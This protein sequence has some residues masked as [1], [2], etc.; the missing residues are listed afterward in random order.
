M[1]PVNESMLHLMYEISKD[2]IM[3]VL[4]SA[5]SVYLSVR[6]S[7]KEIKNNQIDAAYTRLKDNI[8]NCSMQALDIE[9]VPSNQQ[10]S[11]L[12]ILVGEIARESY[13]FV[14]IATNKDADIKLNSIIKNYRQEITKVN[15][16]DIRDR[17]SVS[18][19]TDNLLAYMDQVYHSI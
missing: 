17:S 5:L 11:K 6:I 9:G 12:T 13:S 7:K 1:N 14:K 2:F 8:K 19:V 18:K 16:S 15:L 4:L 10:N 3:P